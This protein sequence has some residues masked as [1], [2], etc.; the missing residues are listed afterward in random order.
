MGIDTQ[1]QATAAA[2][3]AVDREIDRW[4]RQLGLTTEF[5]GIGIDRLDCTSGIPERLRALDGFL[6]RHPEYRER[7]TFV[8]IGLPAWE[9]PSMDGPLSNKSGSGGEDQ[10]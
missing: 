8:Q 7:L 1:R 9:H 5:V 6:G 3:P 2:S 4:K 10:R